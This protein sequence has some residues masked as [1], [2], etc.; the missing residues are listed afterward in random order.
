M[1]AL[2]NEETVLV[3]G[4]GPAGLALG[5]AL[6]DKG[7]AVEIVERSPDW[8]AVGG[9]GV[10]HA[11]GIRVLNQLGLSE[12][13]ATEGQLLQNQVMCDKQGTPLSR[14]DLGELWEGVGPTY[15]FDR[16]S[17]Q[18]VLL[19][20][21]GELPCR[22]GTSVV[23][24]DAGEDHVSVRFETGET[25]R[26][27]LVVGADGVRSTTRKSVTQDTSTYAGQMYYRAVSTY[28]P[29]DP[30]GVWVMLGD[31]CFFGIVALAGGRSYGFGAVFREERDHEQDNGRTNRMR[32]QFEGFG[33]G[34]SAFI[35]GVA[36]DDE[37]H[38]GGTDRVA[39]SKW[40]EG[41]VVLVGDAAH[42]SQPMMAEG[43]SMAL[44]DGVVLAEELQRNHDLESALVAYENRRM[45]RAG[46]VQ[47]QT[48]ALAGGMGMPAAARNPFLAQRGEAMTRERFRPLAEMA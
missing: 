47:E 12:M 14:I 42:C 46:W 1:A 31:G 35:D 5:I 2:S 8:P 43:T 7:F 32:Q 4:A 22:L 10:L 6:H 16:P 28:T 33:G 20:R 37:V 41:R 18:R 25:S 36:G 44:E 39:L 29:D 38:Y 40:H 30:H 15:G 34:V 23:A 9:L 45:P 48:A 19:S 17:L 3:V 11:N 13:V 21:A 26:Y 24:I 27:A